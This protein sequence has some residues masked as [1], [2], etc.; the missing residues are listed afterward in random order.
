M[1]VLRL[2]PR[3][4]GD[5]RSIDGNGGVDNSYGANIVPIYVTLDSTFS[6]KMN[7]AIQIGAWTEMTVVSQFDDSSGNTTSAMGLAGV[8]LIGAAFDSGTPSW[9]LGT[10]WPVI[11]EDLTCGPNCALGTDPIRAAQRTGR[12]SGLRAPRTRAGDILSVRGDGGSAQGED[13]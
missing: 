7:H 10:H 5:D 9:N 2:R 12:P 1:E 11:P 3:R 13:A 4:P 6:D 8:G